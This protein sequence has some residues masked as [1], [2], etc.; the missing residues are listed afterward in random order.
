M[1]TIEVT[2]NVADDATAD[3]IR[4]FLMDALEK[5]VKVEKVEDMQWID[6]G[7]P[8]GT[9]WADR[10]AD[11]YHTYGEAVL[12]FGDSLPSARQMAE[13]MECCAIKWDDERKGLSVTGRNGN[14]IFLPAL[15]FRD[16]DSQ[17]VYSKGEYGYYWT[18]FYD[19]FSDTN[20]YYMRFD[21]GS[22]NPSGYCGFCE[23][24]ASGVSDEKEDDSKRVCKTLRVEAEIS[25]FQIC[26]IA[27]STFFENFGFRKKIESADTNN[28]GDYGAANAGNYGAANAGYKGAANAGDYGAANAGNYGAANAGYKGAANAGYKGAANAG[29]YGAANAGNYGAANAGYKGAA[30]AGY[31]G[32]ANAGYKGAASVGEKGVAIVSTGGKTRGGKGSVLVLVNR[33]DYGNITEFKAVQV[34]GK[35]VKADTWYKLENGELKEA[36]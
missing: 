25:V 16:K 5:G 18:S 6:L 27:V 30:N 7:L 35:Q 32:A 8:S 22:V 4:D 11:G 24:T 9:L 20:A 34:D 36:K 12:K 15:G 17:Y 14:S 28:A 10:N 23:V 1:K 19:H 29:D 3:S 31:K 21:S 26:R 33:D 13:L 2:L